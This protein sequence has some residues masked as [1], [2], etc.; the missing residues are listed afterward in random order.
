MLL[1]ILH[2]ALFCLGCFAAVL[3]RRSSPPPL[4]NSSSKTSPAATVQGVVADPTGA[5]VPNAQ[6]D[7]VD[8]DGSI[9]GTTK[10]DGVG[11]FQMAAPHPGSFTLVISEPGFETVHLPVTVKPIVVSSRLLQRTSWPRPCT[12]RCPSRRSPPMSA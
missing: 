2:V 10:S 12:S 6:V 1:E 7:L 11:N 8:A 4:P 9:A 3:R 5:I